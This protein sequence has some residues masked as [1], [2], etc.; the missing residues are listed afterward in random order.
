MTSLYYNRSQGLYVPH[1]LDPINKHFM[2]AIPF[3]DNGKNNTERFEAY[4]NLPTFFSGIQGSS[5]SIC[6][7]FAEENN[8]HLFQQTRASQLSLKRSILK[9]WLVC[10]LNL[11]PTH[12]HISGITSANHFLKM[13][14]SPVWVLPVYPQHGCFIFSYMLSIYGVYLFMLW[15]QPGVS[16]FMLVRSPFCPLYP[17][18]CWNIS[19]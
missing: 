5:M 3:C 9:A 12:Q 19:Q 10:D 16:W 6:L 11:S 15:V 17:N 2:M 18:C 14:S 7:S 4:A 1:E 13:F 8:C